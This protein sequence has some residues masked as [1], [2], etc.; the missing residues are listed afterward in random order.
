MYKKFGKYQSKL[1]VSLKTLDSPFF[2][3][4]VSVECIDNP[5]YFLDGGVH[6]LHFEILISSLG[7]LTISLKAVYLT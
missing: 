3:V 4:T 1:S 2:I 5:I 6:T 7:N